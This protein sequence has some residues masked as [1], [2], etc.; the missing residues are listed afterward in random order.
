MFRGIYNGKQCHIPDIAAVLTRAW[1]AGVDRI[2][3]A[4]LIAIAVAAAAAAL[5]LWLIVT[6]VGHP[7]IS[8][9]CWRGCPSNKLVTTPEVLLP[10]LFGHQAEL[11]VRVL[12]FDDQ[13][14]MTRRKLDLAAL[15]YGIDPIP[16]VATVTV[17]LAEQRELIPKHKGKDVV[18]GFEGHTLAEEWLPHLEYKSWPITVVDSVTDSRE[19]AFHLSKALLLPLD[20]VEC[21]VDSESLIKRSIQMVTITSTELS[22]TDLALKSVEAGRIRAEEEAATARASAIAKEKALLK[23]EKTA[24]V[25]LAAKKE[26]EQRKAEVEA[27]LEAMKANQKA[28][29]DQIRAELEAA[30][31][32]ASTIARE[33]ALLEAEKTVVVALATKKEVE[34]RKAEVKAE[35]GGCEGRPS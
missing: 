14:G 9:L 4:W 20:I 13:E 27:E 15:A 3:Q 33:K 34:Q 19:L 5:L 30:T 23:A 6:F 11:R 8:G 29:V 22:D 1:S 24:M 18:E 7:M 16:K 25:A 31:A 21:N 26:V 12:F 35:L 32:R 10:P 17:R 2:I 28:K